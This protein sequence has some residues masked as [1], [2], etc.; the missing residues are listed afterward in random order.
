VSALASVRRAG[1]RVTT[2][3]LC[4][5]YPFIA[6]GALGGRG[7]YVGRDQYGAS[8]CFDPFVL[9]GEGLITSP[10]AI[11]VG[12]IGAAKSSLIKTLLYRQV[13][14]F[15]YRGWV[16]DPKGEYGP[17][18]EA[19]GATPIALHP[20]GD[21]R[22]NPLSAQG[23][24]EESLA[25]LH[26]V[27]AAALSRTLCP[28]EQAG[29]REALH[30]V[31]ERSCEPTLPAVVGALHEPSREAAGRLHT[32]PAALSEAC[33]EAALALDALCAGALSGMFD[34]VTSAG[35]DLTGRLVCLDLSA[36]YGREALGILMACATAALRAL[37]AHEEASCARQTLLVVDEGWRVLAHLGIGEWLQSTWKLSR[38]FGMANVAIMH[39]VSDLTAAGE[40]GS[41]EARLAEGLLADAQTR[42]VYRQSADELAR[43][44]SLLGLTGTEAELVA[45]LAAG[46]AIWKVGQR[47]F[48][49][50]HRLSAL[51]AK[52]VNTDARMGAGQRR[53]LAQ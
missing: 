4:S 32:T 29:L 45:G 33:R 25:L 7:C 50:Q 5:A 52:L 47:S 46:Q 53:G 22:L 34:G 24:R 30:E 51:E 26:A 35:I 21:V 38:R 28:E 16:I 39:R 3:H 19:L 9:Y 43:S 17:L 37:I 48:L 41:R 14:V 8:F 10:N 23:G 18:C 20:G 44:A 36:M 27:C 40:A 2:A 11:V 1:H 13:G 49:V 31:C 12:E 6:E 15:G 42:I